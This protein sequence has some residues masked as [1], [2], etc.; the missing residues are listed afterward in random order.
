MFIFIPKP[1]GSN[2]IYYVHPSAQ[3]KHLFQDQGTKNGGTVAVSAWPGS[4]PSV[5][6]RPGRM[7]TVWA[8]GIRASL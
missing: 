8:G 3:N 2:E 4:R 5:P 6:G 1:N 7:T